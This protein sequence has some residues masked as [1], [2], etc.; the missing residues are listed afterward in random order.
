M[1]L[2]PL[3]VPIVQ[4]S[5]QM[6]LAEPADIKTI[7]FDAKP[8]EPPYKL[9][10]SLQSGNNRSFLMRAVSGVIKR[11]YCAVPVIDTEKCIGCGKCAESCPMKIITIKDRKAGMSVRHCIS[12]FCCQE[13]CPADAVGVRRVLKI[14]K[15]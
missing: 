13:M 7:G 8:A 9:P 10:E 14:P 6:K 15:L 2:D 1:G 3:T 11:V 5:I 12:C 4:Q